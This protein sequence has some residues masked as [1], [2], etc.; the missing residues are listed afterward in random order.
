MNEDAKIS[1]A[2]LQANFQHVIDESR[3]LLDHYDAALKESHDF[4]GK[5]HKPWV[6]AVAANIRQHL[7]EAEHFMKEQ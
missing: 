6:E 2:G 5:A 1:R 7:N 3:R 4:K